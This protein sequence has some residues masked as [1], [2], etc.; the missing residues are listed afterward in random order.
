MTGR[1]RSG[2]SRWGL[3]TC[4]RLQ[5]PS[6]LPLTFL[7][8][9][10]P[11]LL[12]LSGLLYIYSLTKRNESPLLDYRCLKGGTLFFDLKYLEHYLNRVDAQ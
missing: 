12:S 11:L 10:L 2:K 3:S 7:Y 4:P 9:S 8:V 5:S 6:S 1:G